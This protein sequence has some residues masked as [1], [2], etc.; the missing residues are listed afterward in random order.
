MLGRSWPPTKRWEGTA[1]V[2]MPRL[3][4]VGTLVPAHGHAAAPATQPP[5]GVGAMPEHLCCDGPRPPNPRGTQVGTE[6]GVPSVLPKPRC[7]GLECHGR[8]LAGQPVPARGDTSAK[9]RRDGQPPTLVDWH[10][11][12]V[13]PVPW[14]YVPGSHPSRSNG[15][16]TGWYQ[17]QGGTCPTTAHPGQL[18][19]TRSGTSARVGRARQPPTPVN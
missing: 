13:V 10:P 17:C 8:T 6:T 5:A 15:T 7:H 3:P 18:I 19:P 2:L 9:A 16:R 12:G 4:C 14:W 1:G 11:H